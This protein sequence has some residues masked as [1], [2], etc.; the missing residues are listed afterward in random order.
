MLL[1]GVFVTMYLRGYFIVGKKNIGIYQINGALTKKKL[2][3]FLKS[4]FTVAYMWNL[5]HSVFV[6]IL[7]L[8]D[9]LVMMFLRGYLLIACSVARVATRLGLGWAEE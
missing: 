4:M 8:W 1:V 2:A 9:H 6:S 7:Y 5:K 3:F